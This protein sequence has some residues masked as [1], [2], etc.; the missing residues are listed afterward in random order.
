MSFLIDEDQTGFIK[1]CQTHNI[2][3]TIHIIDHISAYLSPIN[4]HR[5]CR[6]GCPLSPFLFNLFIEP[7]AQ[8]IR[9]DN[10]LKGITIHGTEYK[11]G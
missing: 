10:T 8:M 3:R 5:G 9:Q 6:Q 1:D 11:I 7:L 2:R 4:L